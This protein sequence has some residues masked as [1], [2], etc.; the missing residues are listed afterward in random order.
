MTTGGPWL[1]LHAF[2]AAS[3]A[4][5]PGL[6]A[7][8]WVQGC[9]LGC[10]GCF[11]PLTHAPG[12]P[13]LDVDELFG[14]LAAA[15]AAFGIEGITISGGEPL[16]QRPALLAL[17]SRVRAQ[18]NLSVIVLTGYTW[19]EIA[20]MPQSADLLARLDVV[21]TGRYNRRL[22]LG[23]GL[24]GSANKTIHLL[25]DRYCLADLAAVP[26]AEAIIDP[27]GDVLHSG[28]DPPRL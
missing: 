25:T 18:T 1:R 16:Q 15:Q 8:L 26:V 24:R 7:V 20:S 6:R 19:Q 21:V 9:S 11:N 28:I 10:P 27:A 3:R 12:G 5:G 4:N 13:R 2:L 22:H 23:A 14:R 17:L